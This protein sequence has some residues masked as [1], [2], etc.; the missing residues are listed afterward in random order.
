[1]SLLTVLALAATLVV[2]LC[3]SGWGHQQQAE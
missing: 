3:A 1:M 2:A